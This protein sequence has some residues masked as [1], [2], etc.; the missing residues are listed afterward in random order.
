MKEAFKE[1][2]VNIGIT[3]L[4]FEKAEAVIAF[5][6]EL[7]PDQL[8]NIFVSEYVDDEGKRHYDN[9][10][11]F[12]KDLACEAKA[13]LTRD[14]FDV[15]SFG[16]KVEHWIVKKESYD[17]CEASSRSR[18]TLQFTMST[19]IGGTLRAS[20]ENCDFL[21]EVLK[22]H[23]IVSSRR[24]GLTQLEVIDRGSG[25]LH[26]ID[27]GEDVYDVSSGD[28]Y[29]FDSAVFRYDYESTTT[30]ESVLRA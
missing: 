21:R 14:E 24:A 30:P 23:I 16:N 13:F 29:E 19:Q 25:E 18:M 4:F 2:L 7:Y 22:E 8:E 17:L 28:N 15:A 12:T 27:F 6:E 20:G 1:Y 9:M 5:Y 26:V 11:L 3:D 10:W